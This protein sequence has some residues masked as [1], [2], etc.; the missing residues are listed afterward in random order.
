MKRR[1]DQKYLV[2][3]DLVREEHHVLVVDMMRR[4]VVVAID[5]RPGVVQGP[6]DDVIDPDLARVVAQADMVVVIIDPD[7]AKLAVIVITDLAQSQRQKAARRRK[8]T[9][10][11]LTRV[12]LRRHLLVPLALH[13]LAR[14]ESNQNSKVF[15]VSFC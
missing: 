2:V 13:R 11:D 15:L 7:R 12:L 1:I 14:D 8:V 4:V 9:R 6:D 10:R 3:V 5:Q